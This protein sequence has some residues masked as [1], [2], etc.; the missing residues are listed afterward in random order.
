MQ[1]PVQSSSLVGDVI[2]SHDG[3]VPG[4]AIVA[5]QLQPAPGA[6]PMPTPIQL[7]SDSAGHFDLRELSAGV[8]TISVSSPGF[9][10]FVSPHIVLGRGQRFVVQGIVLNIAEQHADVTVTMTLEQ[11]ADQEIHDEEKQRV[12]GFFPNYNT[13][14]VW[15]AAPMN[16]R[17]K[18]GLSLKSTLD[19][20]SFIT[21]GI[22]AGG[23]QIQGT[24]PEYGSG[25]SGFAYRYGDAWGTGFIG[26]TIAYAVLPSIFHQDPRYFYMGTGTKKARAIHA[27]LSS[28]LCRGNN[29]KTQ[30]NISHIGGDFAAGY[31]SRSYHPGSNDSLGLAVDNM[32]I[33]IGGTAGV[34]LFREFALKRL[35]T[36]TPKFGKGKPPQEAA[37]A[38]NQ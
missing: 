12:V 14:Y 4:A 28:V 37:K 7:T 35:S 16:A 2:D 11:V 29:G 10:S 32:F 25:P 26:H 27:M 13:S 18:F 3:L 9:I 38:S 19:P 36:G 23:R 15:N 17:Q 33:G 24:Y 5:T 31:I 34:N 30:F 6:P 1:A 8:W 21:A 22:I 20:V